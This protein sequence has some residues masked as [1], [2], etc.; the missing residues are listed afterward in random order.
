MVPF[1]EVYAMGIRQLTVGTRRDKRQA[2]FDQREVSEQLHG[3]E[4]H[5]EFVMWDEFQKTELDDMA[6]DQH[7]EAS[8]DDAF[9]DAYWDDYVDDLR[10][11]RESEWQDFDA[12]S[13]EEHNDFLKWEN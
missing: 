7:R 5:R 1:T 2:M 4:E 3:G 11:E 8:F 13:V 9:D 6:E 10:L 12:I